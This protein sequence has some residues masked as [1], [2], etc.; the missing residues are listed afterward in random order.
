[1]TLARDLKELLAG[2]YTLEDMRLFDFY[3]QT[4]HIE[5]VARLK[6]KTG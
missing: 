5:A 1:V 3:P 4:S 2:P 6:I